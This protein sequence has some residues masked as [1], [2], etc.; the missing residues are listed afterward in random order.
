MSMANEYYIELYRLQQDVVAINTLHSQAIARL[1]AHQSRMSITIT[2]N[3]I[4]QTLDG[5]ELPK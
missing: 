3:G 1:M 4:I 2:Q 5:K